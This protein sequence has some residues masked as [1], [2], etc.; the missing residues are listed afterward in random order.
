MI[1]F[2]NLTHIVCFYIGITL[3]ITLEYGLK[4]RI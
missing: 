3:N 2:F 1:Y 4:K